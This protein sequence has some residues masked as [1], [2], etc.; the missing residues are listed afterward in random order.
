MS[1]YDVPGMS[2]S[3]VKELQAALGVKVDGAWGEKSQ[4]AL[5]K[6]YGAG[7]NPYSIYSGGNKATDT[8][9]A[10]GAYPYPKH[11]LGASYVSPLQTPSGRTNTTFTQY[12]SIA[13]TGNFGTGIFASAPGRTYGN[14]EHQSGYTGKGYQDAKGK[15]YTDYGSLLRTDGFFYPEGARISPNGKYFDAG[16]GRGMQYAGHAVTSDRRYVPGEAYGYGPLSEPPGLKEIN[17]AWQS[18]G[19]RSALGSRVTTGTGDTGGTDNVTETPANMTDEEL[20]R[21]QQYLANLVG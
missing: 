21:Y 8:Q 12:G 5:D 15:S 16:D 10:S 6:Q 1:K 7:S 2:R 13:D 14:V 9:S 20:R 19:S 11:A 18:G 17:D 3:E 4:A